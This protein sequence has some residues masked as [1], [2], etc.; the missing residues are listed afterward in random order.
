MGFLRYPCS[1]QPSKHV[2]APLPTTPLYPLRVPKSVPSTAYP[3]RPS[4][5]SMRHFNPPCRNLDMES[6]IPLPTDNIY[7]F[8]ALFGLLLFTFA[9]A[10]KLYLAESAID[11]VIKMLPQYIEVAQKSQPGSPEKIMSNILETR[12]DSILED[13]INLDSLSN[14]VAITGGLFMLIGFGAWQLIIQ[15]RQDEFAKL[16]LEKLRHEVEQ[17]KGKRN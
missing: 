12:M 17:L 3:N 9:L 11:K 4:L 2:V 6:R 5:D 16:E 1:L 7:K 14:Y 10:S 15:P 8:Y 13:G